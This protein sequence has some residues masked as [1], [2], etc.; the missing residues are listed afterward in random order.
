MAAG[1]QRSRNCNDQTEIVERPNPQDAANVELRHIDGAESAALAE[2]QFSDQ[3]GAQDKKEAE[4]IAAGVCNGIQGRRKSFEE[5]SDPWIGRDRQCVVNEYEK[6]RQKAENIQ[7][8][9]VISTRARF[10]PI[11]SVSSP[12]CAALNE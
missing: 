11:H 5:R 6:E 1:Q 8:R 9:A 2:Q 10:H 3:E 12:I 4:A 7:L